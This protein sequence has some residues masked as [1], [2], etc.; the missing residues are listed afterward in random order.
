MRL[1]T[2][3]TSAS[4]QI[5]MWMHWSNYT[6]M[7]PRLY[8]NWSGLPE[9]AIYLRLTMNN[10][11]ILEGAT[12]LTPPSIAFSNYFNNRVKLL[13]QTYKVVAHCDLPTS[14]LSMCSIDSSLVAVTL[15]N[16][17]VH[18]IRNKCY[19]IA[20]HQSNL[21][22]TDARCMKQL[23]PVQIYVAKWASNQLVT[24]SRDGTVISTF[25]DPV[26]D[27]GGL[28][29]GLHVT[30][31]GQVLVDRDGRQRLAEVI[32]QKD[33][34]LYPGITC[35]SESSNI[36][37]HRYPNCQLKFKR[38][39][40][41]DGLTD[42]QTNRAQTIIFKL[43]MKAA[44]VTMS[45]HCLLNRGKLIQL[46]TKFGE[47]QMIFSGQTDRQTDRQSDSYNLAPI[48]SI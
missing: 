40:V 38:H 44:S 27:C 8:P 6:Y 19:G 15:D 11:A 39:E 18:F 34:V 20:H 33:G 46:L 16:R 2:R 45:L 3:E 21:F 42:R 24:L 17:E 41:C 26:L 12:S 28:E 10:R 5:P 32:T 29:N 14:P 47:D 36:H 1:W 31:L 9:W 43:D 23:K 37:S 7:Y 35:I 4:G 13:N 22:I 25:T 30:D 48:S